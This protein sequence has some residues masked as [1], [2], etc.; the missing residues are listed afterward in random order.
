MQVRTSHNRRA[1]M[2]LPSELLSLKLQTLAKWFNT[3]GTRSLLF[4]LW[5]RLEWQIM[6]PQAVIRKKRDELHVVQRIAR[7]TGCMWNS[8][9]LSEALLTLISLEETKHDRACLYSTYFLVA[10]MLQLPFFWQHHSCFLFCN[11]SNRM[12]KYDAVL[13]VGFNG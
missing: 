10:L 13:K 11:K 1:C 4:A 7:S 2:S 6:S 9:Y 8:Y 5:C 3:P 12:Q